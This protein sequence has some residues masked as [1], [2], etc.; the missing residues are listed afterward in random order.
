MHFIFRNNSKEDMKQKYNRVMT[1]SLLALCQL[2]RSLQRDDL[3][4]IKGHLRG[5]LNDGKFWNF[6]KSNISNVSNISDFDI[7]V[8]RRY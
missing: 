2:L 1:S 6:S 4:S 3:D 5:L 8:C 7:Y